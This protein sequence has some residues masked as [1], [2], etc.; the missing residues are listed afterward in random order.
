MISP[1]IEFLSNLFRHSLEQIY[2]TQVYPLRYTQEFAVYNVDLQQ[3][4]PFKSQLTTKVLQKID[5]ISK[6]ELLYQYN[7]P[8]SLYFEV[9]PALRDG[10]FFYNP[11]RSLLE[12]LNKNLLRDIVLK[13]KLSKKSK[14]FK[15]QY[16]KIDLV[17]QR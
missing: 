9:S 13:T 11:F 10:T 7:N 15:V 8:Q 12:K 14:S 2:R 17:A 16:P 4:S 3:T 5:Q 6:V 1:E